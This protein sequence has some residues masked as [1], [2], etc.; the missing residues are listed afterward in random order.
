[1]FGPSH[2]IALDAALASDAFGALAVL[3]VCLWPFFSQRR[4]ILLIQSAGTLAFALNYLL[5]DSTTAA[6]TCGVSIVQ[7]TAAALI[8]RR[9]WLLAVYAATLPVFLC[10]VATTWCGVP[11]ALAAGG[12]LVSSAARLQRSTAAMMA[13]FLCSAPFWVSHD[14]LTNSGFGL[15][16]DALSIAGNGLGL[17]RC[18]CRVNL[19]QLRRSKIPSRLRCSV[20]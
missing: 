13:L 14:L 16:V 10:L 5:L 15:V 7:L 12:G 8:R 19:P 6:I 18:Q 4:T 11:S 3:S 17:L 2:K 20:S 9:L 1:M